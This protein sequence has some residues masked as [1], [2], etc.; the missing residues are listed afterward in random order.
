LDSGAEISILSEELFEYLT[1][2][3]LQ[4]LHIPVLVSAWGSRTTRIKKQVLLPVRIDNE[5]YEKVFMVAPQLLT[6]AILGANFFK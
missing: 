3:G 4:L 5:V 1:D 2:S 6:S